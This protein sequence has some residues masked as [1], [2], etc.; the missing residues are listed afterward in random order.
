[1][2][3]LAS[4]GGRDERLWMGGGM[5]GLRQAKNLPRATPIQATNRSAG[6]SV[7]ADQSRTKST[8]ASRVSWGTQRPVSAPQ[9]FF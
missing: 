4:C 9:D 1:M 2:A 5:A 8:M 6:I 7:F 3:L